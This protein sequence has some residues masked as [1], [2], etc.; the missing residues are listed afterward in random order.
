MPPE[1]TIPTV[2][3]VAMAMLAV[4]SLSCCVVMLYCIARISRS[5]RRDELYVDRHTGEN[6]VPT[7][8]LRGRKRPEPVPP[9][10]FPAQDGKDA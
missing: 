5:F 3:L 6:D 9:T 10:P 1:V 7:E 4:A 2:S 8:A